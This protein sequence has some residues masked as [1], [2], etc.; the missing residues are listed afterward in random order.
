MKPQIQRTRFGSITIGGK[1]F[2]HDVLIS[3]DGEVRKRKKKL[4]KAVYGTSH[5]ISLAEAEYVYSQSGKPET[6]IVGAGQDGMVHLFPEAGRFFEQHNCRVLLA[7]TPAAIG[8]WNQATGKVAGLFH[9][10]C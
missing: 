6:L 4:S 2:D 5:T 1:P 3:P 7:P 9:L 8:R 10:T